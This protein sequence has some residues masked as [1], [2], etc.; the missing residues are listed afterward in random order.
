MRRSGGSDFGGT[1]RG[2]SSA[3]SSRVAAATAVMA[4]SMAAS[5]RA[6]G[7]WMPP[8]LRTYWRAAASISSDVAW[9]SRPRRVVMFRHM[10]ATLAN[11]AAGSAGADRATGQSFGRPDGGIESGSS[12]SSTALSASIRDEA[13]KESTTVAVST[14]TITPSE[15]TVGMWYHSATIIFV[16][17]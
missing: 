16:P 10:S 2:G 13:R 9:G 4:F 5:V 1:L 12:A 14:T 6:D 11:G 17:T 15:I 8:T 3:R 7:A